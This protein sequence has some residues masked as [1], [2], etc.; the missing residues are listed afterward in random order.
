VVNTPSTEAWD[1]GATEWRELTAFESAARARQAA[2]GS[3]RMRPRPSGPG[4]VRQIQTI[5]VSPRLTLRE[6]AAARERTLRQ[7]CARRRDA[8]QDSDRRRGLARRA[9]ARAVVAGLKHAR[10]SR[11]A[12]CSQICAQKTK[13]GRPKLRQQGRCLASRGLG[14]T[15]AQRTGHRLRAFAGRLEDRR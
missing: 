14:D 3:L 12:R 15:R 9:L 10:Q 2:A 13:K 1:A 11:T 4:C 5:D 6:L 7:R 8:D